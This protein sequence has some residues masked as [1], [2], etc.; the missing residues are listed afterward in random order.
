MEE[1]AGAV[2]AAR[3]RLAGARRP[4]PMAVLAGAAMLAAQEVV[5]IMATVIPMADP[6][7]DTAADTMAAATLIA[8]AATATRHHLDAL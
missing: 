5:T 6:V 3:H 1:R 7:A 4:I 2:E 8:P